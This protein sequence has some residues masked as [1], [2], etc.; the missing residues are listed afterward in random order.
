MSCFSSVLTHDC[1][2]K[3]MFSC[4][5]CSTAVLATNCKTII[6]N[7]LP[8]FLPNRICVDT[9]SVGRISLN[10]AYFQLKTENIEDA[11]TSDS[12]W[13]A[14]LLLI[15]ILL[16]LTSALQSLVQNYFTANYISKLLFSKQTRSRMNANVCRGTLSLENRNHC[17]SCL[18]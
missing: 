10:L 9:Q 6:P 8:C 7:I 12:A 13:R 11:T 4:R 16:A 18:C 2:M 1:S 3:K 17:E 15:K 14:R 5:L